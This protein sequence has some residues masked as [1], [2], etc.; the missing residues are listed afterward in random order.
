MESEEENIEEEV[1]GRAEEA[2]EEEGGEKLIHSPKSLSIPFHSSV[3]EFYACF[4]LC[5]M[6]F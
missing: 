1:A 6:G 4:F 2:A 5:L 3:F